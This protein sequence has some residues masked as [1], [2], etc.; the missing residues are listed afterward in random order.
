ML[1][2]TRARPIHRPAIPPLPASRLYIERSDDAKTRIG[3][4][5]AKTRICPSNSAGTGTQ[6]GHGLGGVPSSATHREYR[7]SPE[8]HGRSTMCCFSNGS[9]HAVALRGPAL[10]RTCL[11]RVRSE[12]QLRDSCSL[13]D[14]EFLATR[15]LSRVG[16]L[17][18]GLTRPLL[19]QYRL[20]I[21]QWGQWASVPSAEFADAVNGGR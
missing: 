2:P 14:G 5:D 10:V 8:G 11:K 18:A 15:R 3:A 16:T 4:N 21:A 17:T 6:G 19:L 13:C 20:C 12:R 9:C 1:R 7:H